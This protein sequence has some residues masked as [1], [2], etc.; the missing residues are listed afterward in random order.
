M[1]RPFISSVTRGLGSLG[2]RQTFSHKRSERCD[3]DH[4]LW[5]TIGDD[6]T[7][8]SAIMEVSCQWREV[9]PKAQ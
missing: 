8:F 4:T 5:R 6:C 9:P 1:I 7:P 2:I 3:V